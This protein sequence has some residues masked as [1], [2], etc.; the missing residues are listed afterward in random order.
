[1]RQ[2]GLISVALV[3]V[4]S[5]GDAG[6]FACVVG[7]VAV[8]DVVGAVGGRDAAAGVVELMRCCKVFV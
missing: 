8:I 1:M 7:A 2:V 6:T 4:V 3:V 5:T